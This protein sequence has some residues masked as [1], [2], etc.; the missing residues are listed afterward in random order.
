M[1]IRN[2]YNE[3][4]KDYRREQD[5]WKEG[6]KFKVS[7]YGRVISM[8]TGIPHLLKPNFTRGFPVITGVRCTDNKSRSF[9]IHHAVAELFLPPKQEEQKRIIHLDYDKANNKYTNLKW[10]SMEEWWEHFNNNPK[11]IEANKRR[12][13]SKLKLPYSRKNCSIQTGKQELKCWQN[14]S[15]YPKC[16]YGA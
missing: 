2:Y 15:V 7:N 8:K 9:Y 14:N 12:R 5:K 13:Y 11:V 10:V 4:W 3:T 6:Q 16:R 1:E